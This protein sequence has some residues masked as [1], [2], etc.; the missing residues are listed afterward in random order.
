MDVLHDGLTYAII[1]MLGA[2]ATATILQCAGRRS[3]RVMRGQGYS[4]EVI[5]QTL[6]EQ[7]DNLWLCCAFWPISLLWLAVATVASL[8]RG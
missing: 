8:F 5:R 2:L 4:D 7:H 3:A 1:Y 6:A